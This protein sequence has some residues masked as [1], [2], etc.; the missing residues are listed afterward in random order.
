LVEFVFARV[1]PEDWTMCE[2][3]PLESRHRL[4][5]ADG[6]KTTVPQRQ[7]QVSPRPRG[8][9][10]SEDLEPA[11]RRVRGASDQVTRWKKQLLD[12]GSDLFG[13]QREREAE[14]FEQISRF[15]MELEWRKS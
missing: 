2:I 4:W 3:Q 7:V 12:D 14:L 1:D 8:I 6:E 5:R 11:S 13:Q 9:E 15:Q 10:S